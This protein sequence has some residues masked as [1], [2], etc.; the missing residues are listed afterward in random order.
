M[1]REVTLARRRDEASDWS[2]SLPK[3]TAEPIA[4]PVDLTKVECNKE[5]PDRG[6]TAEWAGLPLGHAYCESYS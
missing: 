2:A 1:Q 5:C 6:I 4:S 3:I